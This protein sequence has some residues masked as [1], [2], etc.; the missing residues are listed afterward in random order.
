MLL[1]QFASS[2][3]QREFWKDFNVERMFTLRGFH[4]DRMWGPR[5]NARRGRRDQL[6]HSALWR[7]RHGKDE[8]VLSA[9]PECGQVGEEG[10]I[11]GQRER[12]VERLR[13]ISG[14]DYEE[15]T[16]NVL[17]SEVHSFTEQETMVDKAIKLAE[18]NP[19]FG[20]II[21]DSMTMYYR[22]T[23][24]EE[25]R[26]ERRS[27]AGM[28]ARLLTLARKRGLPVLITSQVYTDID[29]G[30]FEAL[31]GNVLMHNSKTIIK[32][33]RSAPGV[34]RATIMKH[35][36]LAEGRSGEFAL[37]DWGITC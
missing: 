21:I 4:P 19:D 14:K 22:L 25:E 30:T 13:Q 8:P 34:G 20:L 29:K 18:G 7:S 27:I 37:V 15:V 35:R 10:H 17:F 31:G 28:S 32:L 33:E 24:K 11:C 23:S 9:G 2:L 26:G 5:R 16:K 3:H 36:N 1:P 12:S 6:H